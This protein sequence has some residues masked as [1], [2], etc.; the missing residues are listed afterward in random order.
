MVILFGLK[1]LLC[2]I[3]KINYILLTNLLKN[4]EKIKKKLS[5][6]G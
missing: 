4:I 5:K 6:L 1:E 2:M 3:Y